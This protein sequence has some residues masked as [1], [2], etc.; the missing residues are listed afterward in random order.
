MQEMKRSTLPNFISDDEMTSSLARWEAVRAKHQGQQMLCVRNATY[1][2]NY[3]SNK[4][5]VKEEQLLGADLVPNQH[6]IVEIASSTSCK[7]KDDNFKSFNDQFQGFSIAEKQHIDVTRIKSK[8]RNGVFKIEYKE[9]EFLIYVF[10]GGKQSSET[11]ILTWEDE[12][13]LV[14]KELI[15]EAYN[16]FHHEPDDKRVWVYTSESG[17]W[18]RDTI[19]TESIMSFKEH[20]FILPLDLV[21]KLDQEVKA[22]FESANVYKDM[23]LSWKRGILLM[24]PKGEFYVFVVLQVGTVQFLISHLSCQ[25]Y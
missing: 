10:G 6:A 5:D 16:A 18:Q 19:L 8:L 21:E 14:G 3:I 24:G 25:C 4:L 13:N 15:A 17:T 11:Y 9:K 2:S 20:R 7:K 1:L 12:S 22:F 23:G